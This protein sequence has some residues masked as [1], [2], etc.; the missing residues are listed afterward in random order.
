LEETLEEREGLH[1]HEL[2]AP[3]V[4]FLAAPVPADGAVV[5]FDTGT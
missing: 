1:N 2:Q 3:V 4:S 5:V